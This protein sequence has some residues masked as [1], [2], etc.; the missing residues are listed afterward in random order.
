M[1]K[2]DVVINIQDRSIPSERGDQTHLRIWVVDQSCTLREGD[3]DRNTSSKLLDELC[4]HQISSNPNGRLKILANPPA[5]AWMKAV[6]KISTEIPAKPFPLLETT[7]QWK[8]S[9]QGEKHIHR[10]KLVF[11]PFAAAFVNFVIYA[12]EPFNSATFTIH[13]AKWNSRKY[14]CHAS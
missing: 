9:A 2:L 7:H 1:A 5:A 8:P 14:K 13:N 10:S 6:S 4:I 11:A 12:N 3:G